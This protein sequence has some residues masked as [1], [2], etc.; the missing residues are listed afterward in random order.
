MQPVKFMR[1]TAICV[2]YHGNSADIDVDRGISLRL[3]LLAELRRGKTGLAI[4]W[5]MAAPFVA[6]VLATAVPAPVNTM[7]HGCT[8][9]ADEAATHLCACVPMGIRGNPVWAVDQ[10]TG[11]VTFTI[12]EQPHVE[13]HLAFD[14]KASGPFE[15]TAHWLRVDQQYRQQGIAKRFARNA[16]L[17][18][19]DLGVDHVRVHAN[20]YGGGYAWAK[21]AAVPENVVDVSNELLKQ[22]RTLLNGK[23]ITAATHADFVQMVTLNSVPDRLLL[24]VAESESPSGNGKLKTIGGDLLG[25][26][27]LVPSNWHGIWDLR[28]PARRAAIESALS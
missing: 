20:W 10:S 21:F 6:P 24:R 18:L 17:I 5:T 2:K 4:T 1:S 7:F 9:N 12:D 23:V 11:H 15:V 26:H 16:F 14:D 22:A 3:R 27:I 28:D 13:L 19:D 25:R 8:Y